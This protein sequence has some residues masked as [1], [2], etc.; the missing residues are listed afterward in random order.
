MK[1]L[2]TKVIINGVCLNP[3]IGSH[4][5][6]PRRFSVSVPIRERSKSSHVDAEGTTGEFGLELAE[7]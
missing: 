3:R 7:G 4:Y 6:N 1:G 2:D 5:N